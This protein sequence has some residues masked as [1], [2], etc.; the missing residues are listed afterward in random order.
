[1]SPQWRRGEQIRHP[2]FFPGGETVTVKDAPV[3]DRNGDPTTAPAPRDVDGVGIELLTTRSDTDHRNATVSEY[4]LFFPPGDPIADG[5]H[6]QLPGDTVWS[7]VTGRPNGWH[8]PLTS[9]EPGVIVL[10]E[11]IK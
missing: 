6:I 10:A 5:A 2:V 11:R 4:R 9:W 8:S 7:R 1:M 3:V